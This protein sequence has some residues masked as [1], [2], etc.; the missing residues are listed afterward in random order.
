MDLRELTLLKASELL[1]NRKI[2]ATELTKAFLEQIKSYDPL[3]RAYLY[4]NEEWALEQ[5]READTKLAQGNGGVLTG[6]PLSIKDNI[7]IKGHPTTCASKIL[8]NYLAP[9]DATVIQKLKAAGAIFIG[10][11]N[12]DE[13]AMGS[14]TENSAFFPTRNPWDLE[15]V[16][17]GSSGGSAVSVALRLCMGSLGSDTGGSIRQP[18]AFCGVVGMKPSYGLVSRFGL[19]A[20]ASSLD[21]IG[22]FGITTEDVALLL[23]FIAGHDPLDST[24]ANL[25]LPDYLDF[26][27]KHSQQSFKI[28]LPK[29]YFETGLDKEIE[30]SIENL[31]QHLKK[32]HTFKEISLPHTKYAVATY[33]IVAPAEASSN[34][35]RYDGIKYGY[36]AQAKN[37]MD[38]YKKSRNE[39]FGKEVKRRIMLGTYV[40]SAGYYD[41]YYLKASK[42]R[43]LIR[44][45]F[46]KAF[47]EVDLILTPTTPTPPFKLGEKITD[48]LQMYLSDIFTIPA[49]LAGLP[50]ISL[51]IGLSKDGLPLAVQIMGKAFKDE[52]TLALSYQIE[53][54][55]SLKLIPP[56][57]KERN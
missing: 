24:S 33:Y 47:K 18:A 56:S 45:D 14:S 25:E 4:V 41:A 20:F 42:V 6:I 35:A 17:G 15:R 36:R 54:E 49:N 3:V 27:Y 26:I 51:P 57:L 10:K 9:Y 46:E 28:G 53:K 39:G 22:P 23:N 34:L 55:L 40:L 19:V 21:Q 38:L 32:R 8:A 13:F 50:A 29:E 43:T 52:L 31:I 30:T 16:P 37:L 11:T 5:A 12:M 1:R 2:S 48:P 7:L 44:E